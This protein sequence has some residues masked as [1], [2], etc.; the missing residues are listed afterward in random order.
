MCSIL[1]GVLE[2]YAFSGN[3]ST[4]AMGRDIIKPNSTH[5]LARHNLVP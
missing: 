4:V 2:S 1:T 5:A 3:P